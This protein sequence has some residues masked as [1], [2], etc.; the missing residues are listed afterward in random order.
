MI[1]ARKSYYTDGGTKMLCNSKGLTVKDELWLSVHV[2]LLHE[3]TIER[4][5]HIERI[6]KNFKI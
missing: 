2:I 4:I 5:E 3:G 6:L 1:G